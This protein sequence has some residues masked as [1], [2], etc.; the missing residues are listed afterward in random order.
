MVL[1]QC[2]SEKIPIVGFVNSFDLT[3][4]V[5]DNEASKQDLLKF[6]SMQNSYQEE[7]KHF[8]NL[9]GYQEKMTF[10]PGRPEASK[11][12]DGNKTLPLTFNSN[13]IDISKTHRFLHLDYRHSL[14]LNA[15]ELKEQNLEILAQNDL[16]IILSYK[17][18]SRYG[19]VLGQCGAGV[20]KRIHSS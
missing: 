7:E 8:K 17:S 16:R 5:F 14:D 15:M 2:V 1:V 19:N 4:Y 9:T 20:E 3:L 6:K 10:I 12:T 11:W 18:P 13:D